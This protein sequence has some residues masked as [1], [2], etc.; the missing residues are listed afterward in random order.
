MN[1]GCLSSSFYHAKEEFSAIDFDI[2]FINL[3][4]LDHGC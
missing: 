4:L 3:A 2:P 1:I